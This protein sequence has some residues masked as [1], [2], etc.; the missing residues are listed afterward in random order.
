ME[1]ETIDY[2]IAYYFHLLLPQKQL[3]LKHVLHSEKVAAIDDAAS[4]VKMRAMYLR[5][6]WLSEDEEVLTLL[7]DGVAVFRGRLAHEMYAENGGDGLLNKCLICNRL[8]RTPT[9][10][11]CRHCGADWHGIQVVGTQ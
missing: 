6:G 3:A 9:A 2:L 8:A 11:Q 7:Q 1:A 10:K 4:R 5:C